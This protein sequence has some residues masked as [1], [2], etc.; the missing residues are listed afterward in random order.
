M[1]AESP[2]ETEVDQRQPLVGASGRLM[3][4][5]LKRVG[6]SRDSLHITNAI[7]CRPS[8]SLS[9][10][11]WKKARECCA[12]RLEAELARV[13][14]K[15]VI[16]VGEH[17]LATA[18]G[19]SKI[20]DWFGTFLPGTETV[21][22]AEVIGM[23]H[24]AFALR[25]PEWVAV[26]HLMMDR[27][28]KRA[29]G[30]L[31]DWVW[32]A[33]TVDGEADLLRELRALEFDRELVAVDVETD[34]KTAM[35]TKLLNV[36]FANRKRMLSI[37]WPDV[38]QRVRDA[39]IRVLDRVK[40][41]FHNG[42]FDV[43][44]FK[45]HGIRVRHWHGDTLF[46]HALVAPR[47]PHKLDI[48]SAIEFPAPRWKTL[49]R[50]TKDDAGSKRFVL[51]DPV[52]RAIY[53]ARDCYMTILNFYRLRERLKKV[54]SGEFLY[55]QYLKLARIALKMRTRGIAVD[56]NEWR[57][58]R[59]RLQR[60]R[61]ATKKVAR[62]VAASFGALW[63][64][65]K[66]GE[67]SRFNP[68]ASAHI[69]YLFI[70]KLGVKATTF[71]KKTGEASF[72]A[73][74]LND[75]ASAA[76]GSIR[77]AAQ[78]VIKYRTA[79]KFLSTFVDGLPILKGRVHASPNV[80]G[81]RTGRWSY[82]DPN[83]QQIPKTTNKAKGLRSLFKATDGWQ[84][85]ELDYKT[86]EV[87]IMGLLSGDLVMLEQLKGDIHSARAR[88]MFGDKF[89]GK[90]TEQGARLRDFSKT[91]GLAFQYGSTPEGAWEQLVPKFPQVTVTEVMR[92]WAVLERMYPTLKR[93]QRDVIAYGYKHD[94]VK[95][96]LS[97]RIYPFYGVVEAAKCLN[98]PVQSTGGDL[99]N[100]GIIL[101]DAELD[102]SYE[103]LLLQVHDA[104]LLESKRPL[105]TAA[106]VK[107]I[108]ER[109]ITLN[110]NTVNFP[111]EIKVGP[112]WAK[113][114]EVKV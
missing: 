32:P 86:L 17:A 57:D 66:K 43:L 16:A 109:D 42:M 75:C 52:E 97:G 29:R 89:T 40:C 13:R 91:A 64:P 6:L 100:E 114:E 31:P 27:A 77:A 99:M 70:E 59:K 106:K 78:A 104:L 67:A 20:M 23:P 102:P 15:L 22:G 62:D 107:R 94:H 3:D 85:V 74:T 101:I 41:V 72:N 54:P 50:I 60:E 84:L 28:A 58:H 68:G 4:E 87:W 25:Q 21:R 82:Q 19:K 12:P 18:A 103:R 9:K 79:S 90:H 95:A 80:T 11:E 56:M 10:K 26:I 44:V 105:E 37:S 36:G 33:C 83:L 47:L 61:A 35:T 39:A 38:S 8:K 76:S 92:L 34:D 69:R 111:T 53:N 51:A 110:G 24:F 93:Y 63:V 46:I 112:N 14:P 108:M 81:A 96:P 55:R 7:L 2:G 73:K 88:E 98:I 30:E 45:R 65:N 49:F 113:M 5:S 71:S 1:L 48:I